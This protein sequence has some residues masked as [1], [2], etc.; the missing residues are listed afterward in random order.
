[1]G[2][3]A[4]C[5]LERWG[6]VMHCVLQFT[7]DVVAALRWGWDLDKYIG[8]N[9]NCGVLPREKVMDVDNPH[10]SRLDL[11]DGSLHSDFW[12]AYWRMM[13][14]IASPL[15]QALVWAESCPCHYELVWV[16]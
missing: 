2:F 11:V 5:Y 1:M 3:S 13:R 7:D 14:S 8:G 4:K 15:K 9:G 6:T 16:A 12:W 10:S